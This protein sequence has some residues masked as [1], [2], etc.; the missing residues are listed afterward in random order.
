ILA[1]SIG[2]GGGAG[3]SA[4]GFH[5][6][7]G[8]GGSGNHS[9]NVTVTLQPQGNVSTTGADSRGVVAQAIGGGGG[10][11]GQSTALASIGGSGGAGGDGGLVTVVNDGR[12]I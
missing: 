1:Q 12:V 11:G 9:G 4:T 3:G 6:I 8:T 5:A 7:G 10:A 2:G